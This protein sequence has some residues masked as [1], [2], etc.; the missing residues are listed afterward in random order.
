MLVAAMASQ[1]GSPMVA[2]HYSSNTTHFQLT[3][4][5]LDDGTQ[6]RIP[7]WALMQVLGNK[8]AGVRPSSGFFQRNLTQESAAWQRSH[9]PPGCSL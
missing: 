4:Y 2:G 3:Q 5:A 6:P 7:V 8:P 1:P 9:R